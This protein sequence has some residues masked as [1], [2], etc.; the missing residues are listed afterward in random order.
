[1]LTASVLLRAVHHNE[2]A[3]LSFPRVDD[4]SGRRIDDGGREGGGAVDHPVVGDEGQT[5]ESTSA[6]D[7]GDAEVGWPERLWRRDGRRY[8]AS[9]RSLARIS[10]PLPGRFT[11][12]LSALGRPRVWL[13]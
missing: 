12:G 6:D 9:Q 11:G 7:G 1:M 8:G 2:P 10:R 13:V 4:I 5:L 3:H